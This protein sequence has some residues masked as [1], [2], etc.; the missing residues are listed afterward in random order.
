MKQYKEVEIETFR[1]SYPRIETF[2]QFLTPCIPFCPD[3]KVSK[4]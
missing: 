1:Q 4:I 3:E 2:C